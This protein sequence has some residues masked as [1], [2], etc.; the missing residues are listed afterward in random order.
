MIHYNNLLILNTWTIENIKLTIVYYKKRKFKKNLNKLKMIINLH[1]F[2]DCKGISTLIEPSLN[3]APRLKGS[4]D[5]LLHLRI[6][7]T[8]C[9]I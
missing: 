3:L 7:T 5:P 2:N 6:N 1:K 9:K 4:I 8:G